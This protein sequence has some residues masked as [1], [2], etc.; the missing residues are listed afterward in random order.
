MRT[1]NEERREEKRAM[2][3][4]LTAAG[5]DF[6]KDAFCLNGAER[7]LLRNEARRAH[8]RRPAGSY[9]ALAG[10]FFIHLKKFI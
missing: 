5:V 2:I 10:A 1:T 8:Y 9:F 6:A 7:E 4:R 3:A